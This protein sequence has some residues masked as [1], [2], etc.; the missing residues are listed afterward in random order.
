[1]IRSKM[2]WSN[3]VRLFLKIST[4]RCQLLSVG[5]KSEAPGGQKPG[6]FESDVLASTSN[7]RHMECLFTKW[8]KDNS[9][10][11]GVGQV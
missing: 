1:M 4:Q 8:I 10:I 7:A 5:S 11:H 2:A 3:N 9:S 6:I